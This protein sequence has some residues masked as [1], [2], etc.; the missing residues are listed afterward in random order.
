MVFVFCISISITS[1]KNGCIFDGRGYS[2]E[3]ANIEFNNTERIGITGI[4]QLTMVTVNTDGSAASVEALNETMDSGYKFT[5]TGGYTFN[6]YLDAEPGLN[7][8]GRDNSLVGAL[9][10]F[11]MTSK[12]KVNTQVP[13]VNSSIYITTRFIKFYPYLRTISLL[14]LGGDLCNKND[15]QL[16]N[17][18]GKGTYIAVNVKSEVQLNFSEGYT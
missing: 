12:S 16:M 3:S 11:Q 10:G 13:D 4:E 14:M 1:A 15:A 7:Y 2:R 18:G 5:F 8:F 9:K 6:P 17:R